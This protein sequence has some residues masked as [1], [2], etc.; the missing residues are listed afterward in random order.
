MPQVNE[1]IT[2][3]SLVYGDAISIPFNNINNALKTIDSRLNIFFFY[4][5]KKSLHLYLNSEKKGKKQ[6][7]Y[8]IYIYIY[9]GRFCHF[10]RPRRPLGRVEV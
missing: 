3:D 2:D 8:V 10:Y 6:M 5:D 7:A 4:L 9:I 1:T